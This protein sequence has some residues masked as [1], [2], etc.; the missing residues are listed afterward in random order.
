MFKPIRAENGVVYY[1]S[2]MLG[3][4]VHGFS[5]RIGGVSSLPHTKS[6]NLAF[7]RGDEDGEVLENV[8]RL[9]DALGFDA[10]ALV[11]VP[12]IHSDIIID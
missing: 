11:S 9:A 2:D 6:L 3:G 12:Q 5:T 7:G 4:A 8:R 1:A 10:D